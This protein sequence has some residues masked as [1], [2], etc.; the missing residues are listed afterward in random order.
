M[1]PLLRAF[2]AAAAI[3]AVAAPTALAAPPS[4]Y[5]RQFDTFV[6]PASSATAIEVGSTCPAGTV[7]W[8]GGV[9]YSGGFPGEGNAVNSSAPT[10]LGWRGRYA[11]HSDRPND[12]RASVICAARPAGYTISTATVDILAFA[13]VR[14]TASCPVGTV[15]LSGGSYTSADSSLS[16]TLS[17]FPVDTHRFRAVQWNGSDH[18]GLFTA[19][20]VC[21]RKPAGYALVTSSGS[22]SGPG[23]STNIG[24]AQ[25]S[26]RRKLVGGGVKVANPAATA[27]IGTSYDS[28]DTQW[29]GDVVNSSTSP[30]AITRYA[31][32]VG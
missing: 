27:A 11:N 20:A 1:L 23:P 24:G 26:G 4:S 13:A 7:P 32:C 29:V 3:G 2:L 30:I 28:S 19:F 16:W 25:C 21:A 6:A 9:A 18:T 15:V 8:G 17:A 22:V 14:A 12:V 5:H 10:G 31:I